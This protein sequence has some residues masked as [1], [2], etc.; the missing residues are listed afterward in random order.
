MKS[1][2]ILVIGFFFTIGTVIANGAGNY[3]NKTVDGFL[4]E[5][6]REPKEPT[7]NGRVVM[8]LSVHNSSTKEPFDIES[9]WIRISKGNN[10]LFTSGDFRITA[11]GPMFFVYTFKESGTYAIDFS[12]QYKGKDVKTSFTVPV[13]KDT[14]KILKSFLIFAITFVLGYA[15]S[16]LLN[17][18]KHKLFKKLTFKK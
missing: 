5:F 18:I 11:K 15:A 4:F 2:F 12:A 10:V 7:A 14:Q 6:G 3:I 16:K 1:L 9:L 17:K 8:S 13:K